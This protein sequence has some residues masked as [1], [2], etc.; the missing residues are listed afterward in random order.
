LIVLDTSGLLAALVASQPDHDAAVGV[1]AAEQPPHL[2]SPFVLA[3]IDYF[4]VRWAGV[5][6]E[7]ALLE[8]VARGAYRLEPFAEIDVDAA[9]GVVA[10]YRDLG[11]GLADASVVVV[12]ERHGTDRVLTLDERHFRVLRRPDGGPLT[13]LPADA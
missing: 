4:L 7:L 10:Q 9:R 3:E 13:I 5:D 2:L 8:D 12:A 1:L 11:I 6:A